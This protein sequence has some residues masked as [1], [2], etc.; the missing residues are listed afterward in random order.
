MGFIQKMRKKLQAALH[1][2]EEKTVEQINQEIRNEMATMMSKQYFMELLKAD[3]S[4]MGYKLGLSLGKYLGPANTVQLDTIRL[5]TEWGVPESEIITAIRELKSIK[6]I[7]YLK[8]QE[9]YLCNPHFIYN[10]DGCYSKEHLQ[11]CAW[12]DNVVA[13]NR[14]RSRCK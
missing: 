8:E 6:A 12:W 1:C 5:A 7:V 9:A 11:L 4:I 2:T 14:Q 13:K 10:E 3:V